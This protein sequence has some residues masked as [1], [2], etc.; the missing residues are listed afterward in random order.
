MVERKV[1]S[2]FP[3]SQSFPTSFELVS[4]VS[5]GRMPMRVPLSHRGSLAE[6]GTDETTAESGWM[7]GWE[8]GGKFSLPPSLVTFWLFF[9]ERQSII[10]DV[11]QYS[12]S[13]PS[14]IGPTQTDNGRPG[15]RMSHSRDP[16][17][18]LGRLEL[19]TKYLLFGALFY[20]VVV[21]S[22]TQ[23]WEKRFRVRLR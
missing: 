12:R 20:P 10:G 7:D 9:S 15:K 4:P 14:S 1:F 13:A 19:R 17:R 18:L 8:E 6:N 3:A 11:D 5:L 16:T 22:S 23:M 21:V 2:V